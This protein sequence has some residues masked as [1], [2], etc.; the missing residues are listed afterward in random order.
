M[1]PSVARPRLRR[2]RAL[3]AFLTAAVVVPGILA[4]LRLHVNESPTIQPGRSYSRSIRRGEF[5]N[6]TISLLKDQYARIAVRQ[7]EIDVNLS[8]IGPDKHAS[9]ETNGSG[10]GIAVVSFVASESAPYTIMVK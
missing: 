5:Q 1:V 7:F 2:R 10:C 3:W 4:A 8:V 9:V 6:F